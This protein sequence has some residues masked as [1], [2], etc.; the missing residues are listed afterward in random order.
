M[1]IGGC[2]VW[3]VSPQ[4]VLCRA[5]RR[6]GCVGA[7][8]GAAL[9]GVYFLDG[10]ALADWCHRMPDGSLHLAALA[11]HQSLLSKA[12]EHHCMA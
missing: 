5:R 9:L 6:G 11:G 3:P 7:P 12:H 1:G 2:Y 8:T 4:A 10:L